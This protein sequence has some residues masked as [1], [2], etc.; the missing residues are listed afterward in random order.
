MEASPSQV[1]AALDRERT[2]ASPSGEFVMRAGETLYRIASF[3]RLGPFLMSVPSDGDLWMFLASGGGL[4]AGRVDAEHSLFPYVPVDQLHDA[5]HHSGSFTRLRLTRAGADPVRWRPFEDAH[6]E[7][8]AVERNLYKHTT[9]NQVEFE[10][11]HHGHELAFRYRWAPAEEFGWVRTVTL[12]NL[13]SRLVE[14]ELLDAEK[15]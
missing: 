1:R 11:I 5:R 7:D 8:P 12:E 10:E 6:R 2:V 15:P 14:I 9:G 3:D 4:T 13:G